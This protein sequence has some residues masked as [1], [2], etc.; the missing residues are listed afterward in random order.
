[1]HGREALLAI[2]HHPIGTTH[3]I[4]QTEKKRQVQTLKKHGKGSATA[5]KEPKCKVD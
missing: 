5:E 4:L 2:K 1:M 3:T